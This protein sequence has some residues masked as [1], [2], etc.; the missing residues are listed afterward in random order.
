VKQQTLSEV[1]L[2]RRKS[3]SSD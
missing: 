2:I 3:L 1:D